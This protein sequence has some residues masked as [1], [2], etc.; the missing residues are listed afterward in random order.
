MLDTFAGSGCAGEAA[1]RLGRNYLLIDENPEAV[2]VMSA[3]LAWSEPEVW[4][5]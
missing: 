1:A 3:R 4:T 5:E 2:R